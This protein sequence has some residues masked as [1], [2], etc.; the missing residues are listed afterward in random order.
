MYDMQGEAE[1]KFQNP[2]LPRPQQPMKAPKTL[3]GHPMLLP[4]PLV[5]LA[6]MVPAVS[7]THRTHFV[8]MH[9]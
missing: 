4:C 2:Y 8:A 5:M 3:D 6:G 9:H 7:V 1:L